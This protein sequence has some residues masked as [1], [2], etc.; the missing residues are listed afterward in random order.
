MIKQDYDPL[1][2]KETVVSPFQSIT[3]SY[4]AVD[5]STFRSDGIIYLN[6]KFSKNNSAGACILGY[7]PVHVSSRIYA[8]IYAVKTESR[9][10]SRDT[11]LLG[12]VAKVVTKLRNIFPC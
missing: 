4:T 7:E 8:C 5:R 2:S 9:N 12:Y 1:K 11:F 6:T 3:K 10:C